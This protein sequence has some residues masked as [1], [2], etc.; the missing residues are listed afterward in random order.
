MKPIP[1]ALLTLAL[2]SGVAAQDSFSTL[3]ERMT[4]KE[5]TAAGLDKLSDDELAAL[6]DWLR[7]HSVATLENAT[8]PYSDTRGFEVRAMK[9]MDD[10]DIVSRIVGTF[11]GWRGKGT[12]FR[13]ENGMVWEQVEGGTFS[14]PAVENPVVVIESGL[15]NSWRL[16]LEDYNKTVRVERIQ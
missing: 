5:F 10:S 11:D 16:R 2:A 6:N 1:T 8:Q 15:F 13:L 9:D 4:G 14:I 3:E 7:R 12:V